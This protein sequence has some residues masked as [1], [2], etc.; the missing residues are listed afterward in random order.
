M[1]D[2][3]SGGYLSCDLYVQWCRDLWCHRSFQAD[4][5]SGYLP[6]CGLC[7]VY[8]AAVY[9]IGNVFEILFG[10]PHR[11]GIYKEQNRYRFA[12][13]FQRTGV[14]ISHQS[15]CNW[16]IR[17]SERY[18][19]LIWDWMKEELLRM[20]VIQ[21]DETTLKVN[22]DGRSAGSNSYMWIYINGEY[23]LSG[24]RIVLYDYRK[25]RNAHHVHDFLGDFCGVLVSDGYQKQ[26]H[27]CAALPDSET[28]KGLTYSINRKRI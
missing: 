18:L 10:K 3:N 17:C 12:Q 4:S 19:S 28:G 14:N 13:D 11:H 24:K 15:M 6:V 8:A 25:T 5:V 7:M 21:A 26:I 1:D 22:R 20:P 2:G 27:S 23:D 16:V 9:H